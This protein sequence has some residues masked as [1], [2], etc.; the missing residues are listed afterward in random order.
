MTNKKEWN[1]TVKIQRHHTDT[2]DKIIKD[3]TLN[4][5]SRSD[6]VIKAIEKEIKEATLLKE[7]SDAGK[8]IFDDLIRHKRYEAYKEAMSISNYNP[9]RKNP[10]PQGSLNHVAFEPSDHT[11]KNFDNYEKKA[12]SD[13]YEYKKKNGFRY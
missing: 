2:I 1:T 6:F 9:G 10:Y 5:R 7:L 12:K 13:D 3:K 4:Y 11:K 8:I